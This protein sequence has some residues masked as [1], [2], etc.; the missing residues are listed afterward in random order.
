MRSLV[1]VT[2]LAVA[3]HSAYALPPKTPA[4]VLHDKPL[5]ERSSSSF[6]SKQTWAGGTCAV[7][8]RQ[9][10]T[11]PKHFLT[12][13][14]SPDHHKTETVLPRLGVEESFLSKECHADASVII[15]NQN[16]F[17]F[18]GAKSLLLDPI[19]DRSFVT[20]A[21]DI[22]THLNYKPLE[23]VVLFGDGRIFLAKIVPKT[24]DISWKEVAHVDP[25]DFGTISIDGTNLIVNLKNGKKERFDL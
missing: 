20:Y 12:Y 4:R 1:F 13:D 18:P 11:G 15:T 16:I 23:F 14:Y 17:V 24:K 10:G 21:G 22:R 7:E 3:V 8:V 5:I 2:A 19:E 25:K 6:L 9:F